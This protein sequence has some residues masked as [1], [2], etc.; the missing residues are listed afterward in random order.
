[1]VNIKA[2]EELDKSKKN[3]TNDNQKK[4]IDL[5]DIVKTSV[6]EFKESINRI[7]KQ[8]SEHSKIENKKLKPVIEVLNDLKEN[9]VKDGIEFEFYGNGGIDL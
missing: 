4:K 9:Y 3:T 2:P 7:N 8:Y 5:K 1:M 6:N